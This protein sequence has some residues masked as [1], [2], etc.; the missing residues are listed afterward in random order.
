MI[1]DLDL[2]Y[3]I[4]TLLIIM[5]FLIFNFEYLNQIFN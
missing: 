5:K 4:I 1:K 2:S 3:L